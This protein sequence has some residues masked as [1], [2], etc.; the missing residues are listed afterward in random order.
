MEHRAGGDHHVSEIVGDVQMRR[1]FG[2]AKYLRQHLPFAILMLLLGIVV[3]S[4]ADGSSRDVRKAIL[5]GF[6]LFGVG[7][8]YLGYFFYRET[9]PAKPNIELSPQGILYCVT[10]QKEVLIPWDEISGVQ[11]IDISG[12]RM[13]KFR[14]VTVALV[15]RRFYDDHIYIPSLFWR[16]PAWSNYMIPE[17]DLVQV[18]FHHDFACVPAREMREAIE[19]RWRAFSTH[20]NAKLPGRPFKEHVPWMVVPKSL[21]RAALAVIAI[22]ALPAAYYWH[23]GAALLKSS[24]LSEGSAALYLR[25]ALDREGVAARL[26]NGRIEEIRRRDVM[27]T[28]APICRSQ[29]SRDD[30]V[31]GKR[32]PLYVVTNFCTVDI[33]LTTGGTAVALIRI[34]V[35]EFESDTWNGEKRKYSAWVTTP[36][37][38]DQADAKLCQFGIC[39]TRVR[40]DSR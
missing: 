32:T 24:P 2:T 17:G 31:K 30:T 29:I 4:L 21:K 16:G 34:E 5:A 7:L 20:P 38:R 11:N 10:P 37:P 6:V 18:A 27:D 25:E 35:K 14:N 12:P 28:S 9:H 33:Q 23:Y 3:I 26:P 39:E 8:V 15:S 19:T 13:T 22:L 40:Q 36:V 1:T